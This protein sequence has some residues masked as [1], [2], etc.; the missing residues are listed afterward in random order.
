[1]SRKGLKGGEFLLRDSRAAD[2]FTPEDFSAEQKQMGA[3]AE[4]F[5]THEIL[6][7]IER[8]DQ[9][10][11][12]LVR[13]G[14]RKAGE[15]GLLMMDGPEQF[16]GLDLDKASSMLVSE[17]LA[18][19]GSFAVAYTAHTGIGTLPLI[20]YGSEEQKARYLPQL[21]SGEWIAAYCLTEP[22][23][24][25]DALASQTTAV[26]SPDGQQYSING[27]KQ[28]ITNGG[29]ADLFTV[30]AKIDRQHFTAF[31]VERNNPGV[32]VG[33]EEK[34]M[35]IKG[36]STTQ[37]VFDNCVIPATNL[38]GTVGQ[39]HKIAFNVLNVGRFKLGACAVGSAKKA[40]AAALVYSD[41]RRQFQQP[42]ASFGAI[43]EKIA[44]MT[45]EIVMAESLV[46]RLAGFLDERLAVLDAGA[47]NYYTKY[48]E[49]IE[50]YAVECAIAKVFC[51]KMLAGVVDEAVQIHG[52]YGFICEY[53]VERFYRDERIN[54]IF[55][56][57]NEINR[58]LVATLTLRKAEKGILPIHFRAMKTFDSLMKGDLAEAVTDAMP[59]SREKTCVKNLK[60]VCLLV[61]GEAA[62][63]FKQ[64]LQG[65]Q[66]ILLAIA[67]CCIELFAVES[68]ILRLEKMY[69]NASESRR[70]VIVALA[71]SAV[72]SA[73]SRI[74]SLSRK[75]SAYISGAEEAEHILDG[76]NRLTRYSGVD[77]LQ[78]KRVIA[79]ASHEHCRYLFQ[80]N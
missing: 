65:E 78:A 38:L 39:G 57:T 76:I 41:S 67:D 26:C 13:D 77:L 43:R 60:S 69:Q 1:M 56:G 2:T 32:H 59:F 24:G 51:T 7:V 3:T 27:V 48:Q 61:I 79:D 12:Q 37:V 53:S 63:V 72:S 16:G 20:Y 70:E 49:N 33:R 45:T 46:Y 50:E 25:S 42:I 55:E 52:G 11:F 23:A 18:P 80:V 10:E 54:R 8:I 21:L 73:A 30:F 14:L 29:F 9:Q 62:R 22:E 75:G 19:G 68:A 36:S 31:L 64:S 74:D 71:V 6:P 35:G 28:F 66:E 58:L 4:Q 40:L 5:L 44:D 34:K 17:K 15:I 47:S